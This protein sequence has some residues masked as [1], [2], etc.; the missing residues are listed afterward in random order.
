MSLETQLTKLPQD[1]QW[2]Y[3]AFLPEI[4]QLR[5]LGHELREHAKLHPLREHNAL[6][7][8]MHQVEVEIVNL[9]MPETASKD[10]H[11]KLKA[12]KKVLKTDWGKDLRASP[13]DKVYF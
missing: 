10:A 4:N 1:V 3:F 2:R 9:L 13:Y 11:Q 12:W 6:T 7:R 8:E 5:K